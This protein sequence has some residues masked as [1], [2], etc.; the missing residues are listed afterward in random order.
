MKKYYIFTD[1]DLDG[2]GSYLLFSWLTGLMNIPYTVTTVNKL[3]KNIIN[4]LKTQSLDDYEKVYFFD[5]DTDNEAI[6]TL[7]DR[8]N[9][10]IFDHHKTN[11][12]QVKYNNAKRFIDPSAGSTCMLLYKLLTKA[13]RMELSVPQKLLVTLVNDYDSYKLKSPLSKKLN[14]VFWN[15]QGDR[16]QKFV[17]DFTKGFTGFNRFHENIITKHED[18]FDVIKQELQIF[19]GSVNEYKIAGAIATSHINDVA[20]YIGSI[21]DCQVTFVVNTKSNKISFRSNN[22]TGVSAIEVAK[23]MTDECGGHEHAAGGIL[24]DKFMNICKDLTLSK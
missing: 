8:S 1:A 21:C 20:D 24:C 23:L 10:Y 6:S 3:E 18:K 7:I 16:L 15:Y 12:G 11:E 2:S 9:V 4:W 17:R 14:T 5:L 19:R 13:L 22:N